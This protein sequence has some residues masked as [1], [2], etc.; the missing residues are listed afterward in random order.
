MYPFRQANVPQFGNPWWKKI[1]D[2]IGVKTIGD[3]LIAFQKYM[4]SQ[5]AKPVKL[6]KLAFRSWPATVAQSNC[7]FS[8]FVQTSISSTFSLYVTQ[9]T[10][11]NNCIAHYLFDAQATHEQTHTIAKQRFILIWPT[12]WETMVKAE[13]E[14]PKHATILIIYFGCCCPWAIYFFS[15]FREKYFF[16]AKATVETCVAKSRRDLSSATDEPLRK[17]VS[18][19]AA[20][21]RVRSSLWRGR[22]PRRD[23]RAPPCGKKTP[24]WGQKYNCWV[25]TKSK[26]VRR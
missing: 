26:A 5:T 2:V 17:E 13:N 19:R 9:I 25:A 24:R 20:D 15:F 10:F 18:F 8:E 11:V 16:T 14:A 12:G 4:T 21:L 1:S 23:S 22:S 7:V 3:A 6:T